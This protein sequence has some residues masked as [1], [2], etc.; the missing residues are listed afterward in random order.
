MIKNLKHVKK[1][2]TLA[3]FVA[4]ET[5]SVMFSNIFFKIT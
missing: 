1:D 4:G 3:K 2:P 5:L